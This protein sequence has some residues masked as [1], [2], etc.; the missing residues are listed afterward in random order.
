DMARLLGATYGRLLS[1][2]LTPLVMRAVH[3]LRRRG[4]IP[5]IAVDGRLVEL[6]YRSPLA[7]SQAQR[8]ARN[9]LAWVSSLGGLG[10]AAA[11]TVDAAALARWLGRAFNVPAELMATQAAPAPAADGPTADARALAEVARSLDG[12]IAGGHGQPPQGGA[13]AVAP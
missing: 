7:Q 10:P 9:L 3:I 2:L 4:E 11:G 8:D 5:D 13:D 12:R 1:E 6:Q